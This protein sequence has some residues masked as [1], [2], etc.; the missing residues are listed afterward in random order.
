MKEKKTILFVLPWL[1]YPFTSGGHQ[2]LYNG[3]AAVANYMN[4]LV[5]YVAINDAAYHEAED[6]FLRRLPQ[7]TLLPLLRQ[8]FKETTMQKC[9]R[10]IKKISQLLDNQIGGGDATPYSFI[11]WWK[12]SITP[13]D[14]EW[15]EHIYKV[16]QEHHVDI[17]QVE[18]PWRISDV[19]AIPD[20]IKKIYVHHEL[21]FVRRDL[22][23]ATYG[24]SVYGRVC[25]RFVDKNEIGQLNEYDSIITL[26]SIDTKKLLAAGVKAPVN[27][28]F[29]I[30]DSATPF[31]HDHGDG[32][33]LTFIGSSDHNPNLV[34]VTWFLE[35]CWLKLKESCPN[36]SF[37][38][39]GK[40]AENHV[41]EITEQYPG[42]RFLGYVEDLAEAI[43]DSTMIVPI[44][45]GSG[46]RMKILEAAN[47]GVPFVSTHV[48][49]EG[50]PVE[51]GKH[52][53]LADTPD[54]FVQ[55]ILQLQDTPLRKTFTNNAY[56]MAREHYSLDALCRNRLSIYD[57]LLSAAPPS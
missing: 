20:G 16:C 30:I 24:E 23:L 55:G 47:N 57:N 25:K 31:H 9:K 15:V 43:I 53:Y 12:Y 27:S 51:H 7:V 48:G 10:I 40:W 8:P 21:G 13:A 4:V 39:I 6:T 38:I 19:F 28:S 44:T 56:L 41:V 50:I 36:I 54:D 5:T 32:K 17:A 11:D 26:S 42:V 49:A 35:N 29:A 18:M 33:R 1:P 45:I 37:D 52:C 34:G 14:A 2:A 3:I 22:E 46:I